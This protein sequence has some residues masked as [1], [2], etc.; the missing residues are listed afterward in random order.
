[1][2]NLIDILKDVNGASFITIETNTDVKLNKTIETDEGREANPHHGRV[3]KR[4]AATVM[5]FQNKTINGYE[6]MVKRRLVAEG[7][8]PTSFQLGERKWG[9]RVPNLPIVEHNGQ[10][11]LE[12]IYLK[13]GASQLL[14]DGKPVDKSEIQGW[15][16]STPADQGGLSNKVTIRTFKVS[17]ITAITINGKTHQRFT[18]KL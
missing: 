18:C 5:V 17:N 11:Y 13:P 6:A 9:T 14:L 1:M 15:P 2:K 7:K 4:A 8:D 3:T 10:Y 12:V 16:K